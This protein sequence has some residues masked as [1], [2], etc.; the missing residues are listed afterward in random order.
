MVFDTKPKQ[1]RSGRV[2]V[3]VAGC[4]LLILSAAGVVGVTLCLIRGVPVWD[5]CK[6]YTKA[7]PFKEM[8]LRMAKA[9]VKDG[10]VSEE[11]EHL[12]ETFVRADWITL[13]RRYVFTASREGCY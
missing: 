1:H 8:I 6:N 7:D 12:C 2:A 5:G 3:M 4:L 11:A 13:V 9:N 10:E